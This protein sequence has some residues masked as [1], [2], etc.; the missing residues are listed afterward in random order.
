VRLLLVEDEQMLGD[1]LRQGLDHLGFKVDWVRDGLQAEQ[2]LETDQ[3]DA[4]LLDLGLPGQ[5]GMVLL[6]KLRRRGDDIP[7]LVLTARDRLEDRVEGLD[8]G[9]D[10]YLVK[11]FDLQEVAARVRAITRRRMGHA[12]P[13]LRHADLTLDPAS[14]EVRYRGEVVD[15]TRYEYA[16][17]ETLLTQVGA[18]VPR[19]RLLEHLY[20]WDEGAESNVLEVC[21]H[22]LRKKL[23]HDLIRTVRGV[24][25]SI[26]KAEDP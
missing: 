21:I 24:G 17:L 22:H 8:G 1:S 7:V 14:H 13:V 6:R 2:A 19:S 9:A 5:D 16:V 3:F 20:G 4:L 10:D 25:Y 12:A 18:V 11:P 15:L 26:R 23:D